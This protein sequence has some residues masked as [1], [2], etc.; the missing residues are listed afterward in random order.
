MQMDNKTCKGFLYWIDAL[1][2]KNE[3]HVIYVIWISRE[4][5]CNLIS[6]LQLYLSMVVQLQLHIRLA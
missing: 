3:K 1:G 6:N 5:V 2:L 4:T